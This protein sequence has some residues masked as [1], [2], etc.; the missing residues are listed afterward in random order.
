MSGHVVTIANPGWRNARAVPVGQLSVSWLVNRPGRL[1]CRLPRHDAHRLPFANLKG[2]W[3]GGDFGMLGLW[4][5]IVEDDPGEVGGGTIELSAPSMGVLL[6]KRAVPRT[7]RQ[8]SGPPGAL[9]GRA[10]TDSGQDDPLW[11]RRLLIDED[12]APVVTEWRG[13]KLARVVSSLA[14]NAG[15]AWLVEPDPAD[16]V[17]T[18]TYRHRF[19]DRRGRVLL[20]EGREV[21]AGSVRPTIAT[22]VNDLTG[23]AND[24]QW[25]RTQPV[26]VEDPASILAWGRSQETQR[27]PGHTRASSLEFVALADLA[28]RARPTAA[29]AVDVPDRHPILRHVRQGETVRLW[30]ASTN[31]VYDLEIAGRAWQPNRGVVTITGTAVAA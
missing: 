26:R 7:Y 12:G 17:L 8:V 28:R 5:G 1:S 3:I 22:V 23:V 25:E 18:F 19:L 21:V 11:I 2:R 6:E 31:G 29:V 15:G 30:S 24:R 14:G 9:I 16:G 20:C 10:I 13:D 4:W 27:Y